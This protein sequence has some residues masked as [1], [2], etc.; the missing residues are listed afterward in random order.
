MDVFVDSRLRLPKLCC[1]LIY[2][3]SISFN[4]D[5]F[6]CVFLCRFVCENDN[7]MMAFHHS[8]LSRIKTECYVV[9]IIYVTTAVFFIIALQTLKH[10]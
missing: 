1:C 10:S 5:C 8:I 2:L 9:G 4:T 6:R 3:L 7:L